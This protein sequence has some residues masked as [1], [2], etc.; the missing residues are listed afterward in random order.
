V[1]EEVNAAIVGHRAA[2][3]CVEE[4]AFDCR[5]SVIARR[6]LAKP[7]YGAHAEN[8]NHVLLRMIGALHPRLRRP[9]FF[10]RGAIVLLPGAAEAAKEALTD[11]DVAR[12]RFDRVG[13]FIEG[14]ETPHGMDL[15]ATVHWVVTHELTAR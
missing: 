1:V 15:L 10:G 13:R 9:F 8:L 5:R 4:N 6:W 14:F 11:D 7:Q 3:L 12:A 2:L